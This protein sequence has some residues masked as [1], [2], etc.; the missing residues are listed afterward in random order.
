MAIRSAGT[1]SKSIIRAV[2]IPRNITLIVLF[3]L[4]AAFGFGLWE[5][6]PQKTIAWISGILSPFCTM[7]ATLV[8]ASRE[9]I[10]DLIE[11]H[12]LSSD[13]YDRLVDLSQEHRSRIFFWAPLTMVY[14]LV[15]AV[16]AI[17]SQF[18]MKISVLMAVCAGGAVGGAIYSYLLANAWDEQTRRFKSEIIRHA[19]KQLE[20]DAHTKEAA[21]SEAADL[22]MLSRIGRGWSQGGSL[23]PHPP[24]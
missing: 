4:G 9:K 8:W 19:I 6:F 1:E 22:E 12:N 2:S 21:D 16:P 23:T 20:I 24:A 5:F 14:A 17:V 3:S 11:P 10:D 18:D 7:C 13:E 15:A